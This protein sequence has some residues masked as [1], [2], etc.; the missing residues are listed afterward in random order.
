ML[1][2]A[3]SRPFIEPGMIMS[4]NNKEID[5]LGTIDSDQGFCALTAISVRYPRLLIWLT[6]KARTS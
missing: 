5:F 1:P 6:T 4:V 3:S 2:S